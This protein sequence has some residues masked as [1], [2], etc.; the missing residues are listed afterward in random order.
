MSHSDRKSGL[1]RS[2]VT[3]LCTRLAECAHAQYSLF[4]S[5]LATTPEIAGR[6][7]VRGGVHSRVTRIFV[8]PSPF[9]KTYRPIIRQCLCYSSQKRCKSDPRRVLSDFVGGLICERQALGRTLMAVTIEDLYR[10]Y[11]ILADASKDN[12]SQ[13]NKTS[14]V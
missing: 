14:Y 12:L 2:H 3:P 5:I 11:G 1:L 13:V 10:N 7:V 9:R 4:R 8:I 6:E